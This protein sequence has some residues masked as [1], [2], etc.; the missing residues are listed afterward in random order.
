MVRFG[1]RILG[2][3]QKES[4]TKQSLNVRNAKQYFC[5]CKITTDKVFTSKD[6]APCPKCFN[7]FIYVSSLTA[8]LP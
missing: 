7:S 6:N 4:T 3:P 5:P 8:S 2:L 1:I